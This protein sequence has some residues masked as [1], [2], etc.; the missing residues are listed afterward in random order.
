MGGR[1]VENGGR[2]ATT[3]H[4]RSSTWIPER[5]GPR[6]MC[7]RLPHEVLVLGMSKRFQK[8]LPLHAAKIWPF[9]WIQAA[10]NRSSFQKRSDIKST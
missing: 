7:A 10:Y 5:P 6:Q 9:T 2:C 3:D 1:G 8:G 4:G